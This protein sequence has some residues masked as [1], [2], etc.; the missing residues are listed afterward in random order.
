MAGCLGLL[1]GSQSGVDFI[2][3]YCH[4]QLP[5]LQ[6]LIPL[7][8]AGQ[9]A[10]HFGACAGHRDHHQWFHKPCLLLGA[11]AHVVLA[12]RAT[13]EATHDL[14]TELQFSTP[15]SQQSSEEGGHDL[16][17]SNT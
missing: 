12:E 14:G 6:T 13:M 8:P 3:H 17:L 10:R 4:P 5:Q 16:A 2:L 1:P 9:G 11:P 7:M 15:F